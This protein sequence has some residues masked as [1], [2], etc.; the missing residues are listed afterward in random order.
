MIAPSSRLAPVMIG[1]PVLDALVEEVANRLEAGDAVDLEAIARRDPERAEVLR[2]LLPAMAMMA[3][4]GRTLLRDAAGTGA[5]GDD[6]GALGVLGDFRLIREHG[7]GGMGVVYE[8]EQLSLRRC[9]ALKVLP[10]AAA[11]DPKLLTRFHVEAQAAAH[12]DHANI[13]AV[14]AVGCERGLNY[15]AMQFIEGPSL[16][17]VI[18]ELRRREGKR[19]SGPSDAAGMAPGLAGALAS[20][21]LGRERAEPGPANS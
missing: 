8:A 19:A 7:R 10:Y 9:V 16:A 5:P 20:G 17:A 1:D 15:Y 3:D 14:Y 4:L 21:R 11:I 6:P 2:Q 18:G 12:L 13:V